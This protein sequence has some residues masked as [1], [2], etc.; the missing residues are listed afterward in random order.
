[1][2]TVQ[3]LV[4]HGVYICYIVHKTKSRFQA[5]LSRFQAGRFRF[6]KG[7]SRFQA[8]RS[9]FK[10]LR[11]RFQTGRSRFPAGWKNYKSGARREAKA[12]SCLGPQ[13]K[14]K[15][16]PR[17]AISENKAIRHFRAT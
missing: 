15:A 7:R 5:G 11:T 10:A 2:V 3:I 6:Q 4:L 17:E 8:G 1:M 16:M 9:L 14:V 13:T 12:Y